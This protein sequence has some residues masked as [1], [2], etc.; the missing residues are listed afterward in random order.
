MANRRTTA[1]L[2]G[3][4]ALLAATS[5]SAFAVR[6]TATTTAASVRPTAVSTA[7]N[8]RIA[9]TLEDDGG[10]FPPRSSNAPLAEDKHVSVCDLN[11]M[12]NIIICSVVPRHAQYLKW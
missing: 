2:R 12:G 6:G 4:L 1:A 3:L 8:A 11:Y 5:A 10:T 9:D 7:L